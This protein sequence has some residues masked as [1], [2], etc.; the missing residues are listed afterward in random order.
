MGGHDL[1]GLAAAHQRAGGNQARLATPIR[2]L[3][4]HLGKSLLSFFGERTKSIIRISRVAVLTGPGMANDEQLH[5]V[6]ERPY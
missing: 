1:R 3:L 2:E 5:N 4:Y 6:L